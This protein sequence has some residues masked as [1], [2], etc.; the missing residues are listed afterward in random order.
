MKN[1]N[2]MIHWLLSSTLSTASVALALGSALVVAPGEARAEI[3][4]ADCQIHAVLATKNGDGTIPDDLGFLA[5]QLRDDQFAAFKGF[6]L[7]ESKS[8][9]LK[10]GSSGI[11]S[12]RS[13]HQIQLAL[14]GSELS[15]LKL[16]ATL[17]AGDKTLVDTDYKIENGGILLIGGVRHP[18]GKIFFAIQCRG[19]E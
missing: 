16:H 18:D 15:K 6:R 17:Q 13:G 4:S 1:R 19:G 7:L 5:E 2:P 9:Q 11:A 12:M 10:I 8:L 14:L 3:S